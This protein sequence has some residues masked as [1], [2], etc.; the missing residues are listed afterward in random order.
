[1]MI[2][3]LLAKAGSAGLSYSQFSKTQQT[4]Q[5]FTPSVPFGDVIFTQTYY[6]PDESWNFITSSVWIRIFGT[7]GFLGLCL[8]ILV[9][10][11][12]TVSACSGLVDGIQ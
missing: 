2:C 6:T 3:N 9:M 1:M 5:P 10:F 12:G 8:T 7:G 11:T 4:Y